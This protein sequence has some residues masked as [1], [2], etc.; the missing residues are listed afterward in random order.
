MGEARNNITIDYEGVLLIINNKNKTT[1]WT[2]WMLNDVF[3][4]YEPT[5]IT[6]IPTTTSIYDNNWLRY[7]VSSQTRLLLIVIIPQ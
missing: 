6:L 2:M 5:M 4:L 3:Y 1:I 7:L